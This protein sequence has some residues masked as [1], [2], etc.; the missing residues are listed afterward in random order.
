MTRSDEAGSHAH[1][2]VLRRLG[3]EARDG[4]L[5]EVAIVD[6]AQA[7][8]LEAVGETV[9]DGVVELAG[10]GGDELRC[11]LRHDAFA[12]ADLDRLREGVDV[13]TGDL[14]DDGRVQ[15]TRGEAGVLGLFGDQ[16]RGGLDGD[17][18]ELARG[19]AVEE[20]ADG[21]AGDADGIDVREA[22]AAALDGADDLVDVDGFEVA[23]AL[24]HL[25][26]GRDLCWGKMGVEFGEGCLQGLH[27]VPFRS[28]DSWTGDRRRTLQKRR[29]PITR[30]SPR[31]R[32]QHSSRQVFGLAGDL[33]AQLPSPELD[34][35][36]IR[37]VRSCLPLRDSPGF[38]PDSL[39][40]LALSASHRE[41][42]RL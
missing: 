28:G 2:E 37:S 3:D 30:S 16:R 1:E 9:V 31:R 24:A 7:E 35:C 13:L 14:L 5:Q 12:M 20:A 6:G 22:V 15:Q 25:H 33:L 38:T 26:L 8:V 23:V 21:L 34:Q 39:L 19:G 18:V 40:R 41:V 32:V 36:F 10:V 29:P 42:N 4:V 27:G 17:G 11:G